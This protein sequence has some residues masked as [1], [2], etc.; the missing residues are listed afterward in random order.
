M[1]RNARFALAVIAAGLAGAGPSLAACGTGKMAGSWTFT[2]G[3]FNC[4]VTI[5]AAG[6]FPAS[7]CEGAVMPGDSTVLTAVTPLGEVTLGTLAISSVGKLSG[8]VATNAACRIG[9]TLV[10]ENTKGVK[11]TLTLKGRT[12][13]LTNMFAASAA[14]RKAGSEALLMFGGYRN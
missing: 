7:P 11:T 2:A 13:D 3:L 1:T 5:D 4:A 12:D 9:G 10:F 14:N 6:G 8:K